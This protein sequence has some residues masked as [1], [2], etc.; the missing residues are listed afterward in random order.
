MKGNVECFQRIN[1]RAVQSDRDQL[2]IVRLKLNLY[3][4]ILPPPLFFFKK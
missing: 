4:R 2:D 3:Q 1:V